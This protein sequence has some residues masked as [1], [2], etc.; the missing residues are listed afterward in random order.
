MAVT[1]RKYGYQLGANADVNPAGRFGF[2]R[3]VTSGVAGAT[4]LTV[5]GDKWLDAGVPATNN[6]LDVPLF[7]LPFDAGDIVLTTLGA[8]TK[9]YLVHARSAR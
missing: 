9:A 2:L 6:V 5:E 1:A 4:T 3:L 8:N 7:D